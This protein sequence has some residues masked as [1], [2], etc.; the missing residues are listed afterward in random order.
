MWSVTLRSPDGQPTEYRIERPLTSIGRRG[1]NDIVIADISASRS[2]AEITFDDVA[3]TLYIRDLGSTNGTFVNRERLADTRRLEHR[4]VIRIGENV[5]SITRSHTAERGAPGPSLTHALT[6]DIVLESI[7]QHSVLM[8]EIASKLNTILDLDAALQEVANMLRRSLGADRCE[9]IL[10]DRFDQLTS[11][12]FPT[13]V[14]KMVIERR[15]A[16]IVPD[17]VSENGGTGKSVSLLKIRSILCVPIVTNEELLGLI[18]MYKTQA[19]ERP[20]DQRDFLLAVA[21]SH[22]AS[23]T[24]QRMQLLERFQEEQRVRQHLERFVGEAEAKFISREYLHSGKLPELAEH[25]ATVLFVDIADSTGLAERLGPQRLGKILTRYYQELTKV[26]AQYR[27]VVNKF[28]G[29]G[30]MATFGLTGD[31]NDPEGRAVQA[32]LAILDVVDAIS[33]ELGE[34]LTIGVGVN[35]GPVVAG[36]VATKA[37]I[38]LAVLGDTVNVAAGLQSKARPN[39]LFVGP[40]TVA[41]VIGRFSTTREGAIVVKGR[42]RKIHAHEVLRKPREG[43]A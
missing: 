27:G 38:E 39:R 18:Y 9:V 1:D 7:D 6:R 11:L 23:L 13:S 43:S 30:I 3:D 17:V 36:Y 16:I 25:T 15:S 21:I 12:G 2:H 29:D 28:L 22:Q 26:I 37:Q 42:T 32:G 41:A 19:S 10:A 4:D 31:Q 8:Y 5:L 40:A 33:A 14:A 34:P 20:F 35:S 24:I